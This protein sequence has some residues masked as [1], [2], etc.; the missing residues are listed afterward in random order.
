MFDLR[1]T[2]KDAVK[3]PSLRHSGKEEIERPSSPHECDSAIVQLTPVLLDVLIT[4]FRLVYL[5]LVLAC[6]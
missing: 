1:P 6:C 2:A 5:L 3:T 4:T